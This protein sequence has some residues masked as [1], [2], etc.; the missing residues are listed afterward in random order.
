MNTNE[1]YMSNEQ[2]ARLRQLLIESTISRRNILGLVK[3]EVKSAAESNLI[4]LYHSIITSVSLWI[5]QLPDQKKNGHKTL[6]HKLSKLEIKELGLEIMVAVVMERH[7]APIQ[8]VIAKIATHIDFN[9]EWE[10][11]KAAAELLGAVEVTGLYSL[12]DPGDGSSILL[13]SNIKLDDF[14][15]QQIDQ[16]RYLDPMVCKPDDWINQYHGGYLTT[17]EHCI[18]GKGNNH[19][20]YQA[21]DAL[22][23]AQSVEWE[24]DEYMLMFKEEPNKPESVDTQSKKEAFQQMINASDGVYQNML[25][26]GNKFYFVHKYDFRGR[27]YTQGYY[28]NLQSTS[29]KRSILNFKQKELIQ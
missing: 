18:L 15:L 17:Q 23:I 4:S 6:K 5:S 2:L 12:I 10:G 21:L 27:M 13:K 3:R 24:L 16:T 19:S 9:D 28:I 7:P 1:Q 14:T 26:H 11:I 8:S 25:D 29:Y 20:E 22:N